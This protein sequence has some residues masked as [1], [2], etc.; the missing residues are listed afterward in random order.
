MHCIV[1]FVTGMCK[2]WSGHWL[3]QFD[4]CSYTD[5]LHCS[6][7]CVCTTPYSCKILNVKSFEN[8]PRLYIL[9]IIFFEKTAD[10]AVILA[11]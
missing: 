7:L 11:W 8:Q 1:N 3:L 9:K 6:L 5:M 4:Y 2:V 10:H